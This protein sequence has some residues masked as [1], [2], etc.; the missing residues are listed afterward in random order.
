MRRGTVVLALISAFGALGLLFSAATDRRDRAF[1]VGLPAVRVVGT[2]EPGGQ[3]CRERIDVPVAFS[4]VRLLVA[5]YGATGPPLAITV[6]NA[7]TQRVLA[8]GRVA[9]GYADN[10]TVD[11]PVGDVPAG[12]PVRLCVRNGGALPVALRGAPRDTIADQI[13]DPSLRAEPAVVFL[14][15][16]S[17]SVL[18]IVPDAFAR[19][20][21]F[22]AHWLGAWAF[23]LLLAVVAAG[24]PLVLAG[25]IR[26]A[27]ASERS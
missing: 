17:V 1:S 14:R 10:S 26:A 22:K 21:R 23:W 6:R 12:G 8:H 25:A 13:A 27:Y 3:L 11:A 7:Q 2:A 5:T 20:A 24:L 9:A 18:S 19:A 15:R 4:R 16:E